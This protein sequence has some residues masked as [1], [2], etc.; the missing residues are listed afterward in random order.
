M[1]YVWKHPNSPYWTA[2]FRNDQNVWVKKTTKKTAKTTALVLAL[3]WERAAQLGRDRV[4]TESLSREIIGGILE[5]TAGEKLRQS[6]LREFMAEW[7][8]GKTHSRQEGTA[9]RYQTTADRF[10][11]FMDRKADLPIAAITPHDCQKFYDDLMAQD[12]APATLRCEMKTVASVFN[13]ARR[14]GLIATNP[15]TAVQLPERIKQ[16]KR[17]TFTPA[18]VQMLLD[19]ADA[20]WKTAILLGYYAGLRM[21]DAVALEWASVEFTHNKLAVEQQKTGDKLEIPLHPTLEEHLSKLAGD[22]AGP[23][24]PGLAA[25]RIGG[26][27]GLSRK[28]IALMKK[29]GISSEAV[30]TAGK[31]TLARLSF[32]A[33]RTSFNSALFNKGV[34]QE[35]RRKLTG[36]KSD[37]VN[38]KYTAAQIQTLRDAVNKLPELKP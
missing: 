36:H 32:H 38:D 34:D 2:V 16:V 30:D 11:R 27:S 12:L 26:R 18:Q 33:L 8:R 9:A 37:A 13:Y 25:A 29:A 31:R 17:M 3:E 19:A 22:S 28:F 14:L 23:I 4:L 24:C 10:I 20:E 1:A 6:K 35:L 21:S 15:A 5:R 7:L